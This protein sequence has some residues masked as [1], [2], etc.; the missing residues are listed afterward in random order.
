MML[1]MGLFA[2]G[3]AVL[4]Y[5]LVKAGWMLRVALMRRMRRVPGN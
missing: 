4:G 2:L 3:S 1:G 5:V